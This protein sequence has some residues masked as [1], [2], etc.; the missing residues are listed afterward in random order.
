YKSTL[1]KSDQRVEVVM[2]RQGRAG[3]HDVTVTKTV[4]LDTQSGSLL[5]MDYRLEGLPPGEHLTFGV[6]FN[7]AAMAAG[8]DDRF[9]YGPDGSPLGQL[10]TVAQYEEFDR[11]GL[12]DEWLG[13]DVS[14][15]LSQPGTIWTM[16]IQTVSQ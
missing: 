13:I 11:L 4:A 2:S 3:E 6:E 8:A 12:V 16:P 14:L 7:F 10:Q 9:F 5:D 1:R 15:D